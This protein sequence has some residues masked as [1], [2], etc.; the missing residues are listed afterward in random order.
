MIRGFGHVGTHNRHCKCKGYVFFFKYVVR[1]AGHKVHREA[2]AIFWRTFHHEGK[3]HPSYQYPTLRV[4]QLT[5]AG[6]VRGVG[7]GVYLFMLVVL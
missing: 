1:S 4:S 6:R 7:M 2:M 5:E 3:N